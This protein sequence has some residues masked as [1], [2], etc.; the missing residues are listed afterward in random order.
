MKPEID[1]RVGLFDLACL[2]SVLI[3]A[4]T[5]EIEV[6]TLDEIV[7]ERGG[8]GAVIAARVDGGGTAT[9]LAIGKNDREWLVIAII[10]DHA[11]TRG[12]AGPGQ[13]REIGES[14]IQSAGR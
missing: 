11:G 8:D 12:H 5:G 10:Q 9:E 7:G 13:N 4:G 2:G 14:E 1:D 6:T 3:E